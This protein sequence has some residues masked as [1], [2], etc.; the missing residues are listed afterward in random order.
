MRSL[1]RGPPGDLTSRAKTCL[2]RKIPE[3]LS[4]RPWWAEVMETWSLRKPEH[5]KKNQGERD[6]W[7]QLEQGHQEQVREMEPHSAHSG[8]MKRT[9]CHLTARGQASVKQQ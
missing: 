8:H 7:E 4:W 9:G 6:Q 3:E 5:S 1:D 2:L